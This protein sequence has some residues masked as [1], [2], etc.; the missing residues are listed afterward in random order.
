MGTNNMSMKLE[1]SMDESACGHWR[2]EPTIR[3][4]SLAEKW[5]VGIAGLH[6]VLSIQMDQHGSDKI[7]EFVAKSCK[8]SL[9]SW[10]TQKIGNHYNQHKILK[11]NKI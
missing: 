1:L 5:P 4:M 10:K 11:I 3:S 6:L 7:W 8:A 9:L 2:V